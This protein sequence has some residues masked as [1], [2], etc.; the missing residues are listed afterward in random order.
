VFT[1][2]LITKDSVVP[3]TDP[4]VAT[5][6]RAFLNV[7][8]EEGTGKAAALNVFLRELSLLEI[9]F[10]KASIGHQLSEAE[11]QHYS[12]LTAQ[13]EA[14]I[15]A[16]E[17]EINL[18]KE[19][20]AEERRIKQQKEECEALS[21]QV[22]EETPRHVTEQ[23]IEVARTEL[24]ELRENESKVQEHFDLRRKQF[25]LLMHSIAEL[26]ETLAQQ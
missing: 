8:S 20:L 23:E 18:L 16:T 13:V 11:K 9:E 4:S 21:A 15:K 22:N 19:T 24:A 2:R 17:D 12:E 10:T 14:K 26:N 1:K 6:T 3:S 5:V 25:M 7:R